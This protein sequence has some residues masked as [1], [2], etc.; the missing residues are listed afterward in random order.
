MEEGT[1]GLLEATTELYSELQESTFQD[2]EIEAND[3]SQGG[4]TADSDNFA[5]NHH[6]NG[7]S[8]HQT[9]KSRTGELSSGRESQTAQHETE[10]ASE[11]DLQKWR[12]RTQESLVSPKSGE[13]YPR[14]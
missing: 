13:Q 14:G 11:I 4:I 6:L 3:E 8:S 5:Q 1:Q 9:W 12:D 7:N 10:E 2:F